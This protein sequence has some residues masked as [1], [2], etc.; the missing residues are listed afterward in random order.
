MR[1]ISCPPHPPG[2]VLGCKIS[3]FICFLNNS[4]WSQFENCTL[5][6]PSGREPKAPGNCQRLWT[7]NI[8]APHLYHTPFLSRRWGGRKLCRLLLGHSKGRWAVSPS[9]GCQVVFSLI[10]LWTS[11]TTWQS[12]AAEEWPHCKAKAQKPVT[13]AKLFNR[14]LNNLAFPPQIILLRCF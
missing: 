9:Y 3:N 7:V 14:C 12:D 1:K 13:Q 6:S 4:A 11:L 10:N 5:V 2:S 8:W